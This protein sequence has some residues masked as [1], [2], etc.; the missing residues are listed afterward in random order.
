M[1]EQIIQQINASD[2]TSDVRDEVI[3]KLNQYPDPLTEAQ[4]GEFGAFLAQMEE[5][6]RM[7]SIGLNDAANQGARLVTGLDKNEEEYERET[8]EILMDGLAAAQ[9]ATEPE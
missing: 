8:S 5:E 6:E 2:L 7:T 9:D 4:L 3:A 1:K